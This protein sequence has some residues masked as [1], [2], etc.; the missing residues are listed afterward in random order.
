MSREEKLQRWPAVVDEQ[1][2][3][4]SLRGVE[5]DK[6]AFAAESKMDNMKDVRSLDYSQCSKG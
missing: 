6:I 3:T 2:P 4:V 5:I 1:Q